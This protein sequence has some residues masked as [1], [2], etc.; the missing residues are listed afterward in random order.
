MAAISVND[1]TIDY[2]NKTIRYAGAE[3]PPYPVANL[4]TVKDRKSVV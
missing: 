1:F 2:I 4:L 3:V